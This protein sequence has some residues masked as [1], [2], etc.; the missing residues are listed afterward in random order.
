M[1]N[2]VSR[3]SLLVPIFAFFLITVLPACRQESRGPEQGH[4]AEK[5][6]KAETYAVKWVDLPILY[7]FPGSTRAKII[8]NIGAKIPGYIKDIF[9][10]EGDEVA[11]GQTLVRIDETDIAAKIKA[12]EASKQAVLRRKKAIQ[13]RLA[14]ADSNFSR[15]KRLFEMESA[16]R[17]E[18]DRA[19]SELEALK[20]QVKAVEAEAAA[21]DAQVREV[22]NQLNYLRITSPVSGWV[23]K[24]LADPGTLANPGMV[25]LS[26]ASK[27]AGTW[28]E[29]MV[30][31][32][33]QG[34]VKAGQMVQVEVPA[35]SLAVKAPI[36]RLVPQV[37]PAS[38]AF[39]VK[40][41]LGERGLK[42][43]LFGTLLI[44]SGRRRAVLIPV[45]AL[46]ER[47]GIK[48]VFTVGADNV[49]HWRVIKIGSLWQR[50]GS[51]FL[52][53][54]QAQAADN[55]FAEVLAGINH[56]DI[57]ITSD[58]DKVQEGASLE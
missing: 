46:V 2:L 45:K 34:K 14:Y 48:G 3:K 9:V 35:A 30:D 56:G 43:G 27:E 44:E 36:A 23:V 57:V 17:E 47:G 24:R 53:V 10:E 32:E 11:P 28:F 31:E 6:I 40:V 1:K 13:S 50:S 54:S 12:L 42:S 7:S 58:L 19:T 22:K 21:V 20:A 52:Q 39:K 25:L 41:D 51:T 26:L 38:H 49:I 4:R 15:I 5:K 16:T 29:A 8:V 33:L 18:L 55:V 37:N